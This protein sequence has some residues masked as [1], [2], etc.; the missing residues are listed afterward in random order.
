MCA[1]QTPEHTANTHGQKH[2]A[3]YLRRFMD[4]ITGSLP[5]AGELVTGEPGAGEPV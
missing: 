4:D 5:N 1:Q 2:A 3:T